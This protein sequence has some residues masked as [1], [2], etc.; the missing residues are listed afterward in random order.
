MI[1]RI[2]RLAAMVVSHRQPLRTRPL[3]SI[4]TDLPSPGQAV[5]WL[6]EIDVAGDRRTALFAHPRSTA[7]FAVRA[8][9]GDVVTAG[10]ALLPDAWPRNTGGVEFTLTVTAT[11]TGAG[12]S[13]ARVVN[14]G[15]NPEDR[16]WRELRVRAPVD[17][18]QPITIAL[19]TSVPPGAA[20]D[21]AWAI[22][23]DPA[24]TRRRPRGEVIEALTR[25]VATA[26]RRGP[27]AAVR[28]LR[29]DARLDERTAAYRRWARAHAPGAAALATMTSGQATLPYRPLISIIT[30]VYN[31]DPAFLR[32][33]IASVRAQAYPN[34]ELCLCDDGST[35]EATRAVLREQTDPRIH[36]TF[37][38][39][40]ARI[41]AASNAAL[42]RARGE[43]VAL[44]D[45]DDELTPDALYRVVRHLNDAPGADVVYS[46][47]DKRDADGG[48]SEPF[49]KPCWSPEHLLSAM[50]TCHLTVA[51]KSLVDRIGGFRVGYEGAQ[52]HDL[53]LRLSDV[54]ER[55]DH[56]PHVLY[57]WRRAPESTA[58]AGSAKPWADDAGKRALEDYLARHAIEG[59]V[60]S[61]GVPGLYRVKFAI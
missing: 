31:T 21:H 44:L 55:I 41:S 53:M 23:G 58:T 47:E 42:T 9:P 59:E 4:D 43:F 29:A 38:E 15:T 11:A 45:H 2:A 10:C 61:G 60:V 51:R 6:G 14:P 1:R 8:L 22:W 19:T 52:D 35:L 40:N 46:D 7:T 36:L 3:V 16:R 26:A 20:T 18:E 12:A 27:R 28:E 56:L 13:D 25:A 24:V 39:S 33:C 49:F 48:L 5:R 50:Y 57:H 54:T 30:P 34:W 37:L 17:R 32:A